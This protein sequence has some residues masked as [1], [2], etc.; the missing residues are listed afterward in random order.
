M[1]NRPGLTGTIARFITG[2][3]S[4]T[5]SDRIYEHAKVAFLDWFGVLVAGKDEPLVKKLIHHA[6]QMG[7]HPQATI[8]GQGLK[9]NVSQAA[10]ING[11]MSHALDYDDTMTHFLGHPSVTLFPALMALSEWKGKKGIDFLTAYII[12]LKAGA[13]IGACAGLEH[14]AAGWH[15][16]ST[17]GRLASTA[18]CARLLGLNER[19]TVYALGIAGTQASGLKRVFGTMSKPYHA[20]KAAQVGVES[21]LLAE[22][23]FTCAE[24]ILEGPDGFFH[25]LKGG[26]NEAA[27][28]SLGKTWE[29]DML[30]PKYHASCHGTHSAIEAALQIVGQEKIGVGDIKSVT[31]R[32]SQG[33]ISI[34]G[35]PA[36][37]TG[38]EGK[39]SL[40][41][42]VANALL[43]GDT[44]MKAFTDEKVNDPEIKR[45]MERISV[46]PEAEIGGLAA[47]VIIKTQTQT[48]HQAFSDVLNEIP[49][50][51]TKKKKVKEKFMDLCAPVLGEG[52]AASVMASILKLEDLETM[53]ALMQEIGRWNGTSDLS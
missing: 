16:T 43:R 45:F 2:T 12:G 41:F 47:Y 33:A 4:S 36:P 39:F 51:E 29:T 50:L 49:D 18:G 15:G 32:T 26:E 30:V 7:W 44:G 37:K 22:D 20:G 53:K 23:G 8:P 1:E 19:Q 5:I 42:C 13:V 40:S 46:V 24:D 48:V 28:A 17:I 10:L 35:K 11:A 14:Y 52:K 9:K 34:A 31:I 25:L 21:V 38:L 27:V 3:D 6:D